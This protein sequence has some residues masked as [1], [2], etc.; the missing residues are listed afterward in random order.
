MNHTRNEGKSLTED[1]VLTEDSHVQFKPW[2]VR[3]E[4]MKG[5]V[6]EIEV[7]KNIEFVEEGSAD[8]PII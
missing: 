3:V 6:W 8:V 1:L 2:P 5:D 4:K 7:R